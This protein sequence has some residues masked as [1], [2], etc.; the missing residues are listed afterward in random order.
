MK[1]LSIEASGTL[2]CAVSVIRNAK[3][4]VIIENKLIVDQQR[5]V[6]KW[7]DVDAVDVVTDSLDCQNC[8]GAF[9]S[10]SKVVC[11]NRTQVYC[12]EFVE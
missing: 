1:V 3:S 4:G 11:Y 6:Y 8:V 2:C 9:I 10:N 5:V 7:T 12:G